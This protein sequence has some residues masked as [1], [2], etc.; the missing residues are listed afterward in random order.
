MDSRQPREA[1]GLWDLGPR[2][3]TVKQDSGDVG[4]G[5]SEGAT[6][7]ETQLITCR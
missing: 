2:E 5:P 4:F 7:T 1:T 3:N 6:K